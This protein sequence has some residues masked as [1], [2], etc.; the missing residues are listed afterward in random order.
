VANA[1]PGDFVFAI[2]YDPSRLGHG[3]TCPGDQAK[4]GFPCHNFEDG[5]AR[6]YLDPIS[7]TIPILVGSQ[8]GHISYVN[9]AY[10]Q[11]PNICGIDYQRDGCP[12]PYL[13]RFG[14]GKTDPQEEEL[15][16]ALGQLN[17]NLSNLSPARLASREADLYGSQ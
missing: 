6:T 10:L 14:P 5:N 11:V 12:T 8:S 4:V 1:K 2:M 16:A 9:S 3:P 13:P 7:S 15:M 17:E